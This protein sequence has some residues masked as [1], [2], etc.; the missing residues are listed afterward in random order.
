MLSFQPRKN[1][2]EDATVLGSL[3]E[4]EGRVNEVASIPDSSSKHRGGWP[5]EYTY[6]FPHGHTTIYFITMVT[7]SGFRNSGKD[8]I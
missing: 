8:L 5:S 7:R 3:F 4:T 2:H 6:A 1:K